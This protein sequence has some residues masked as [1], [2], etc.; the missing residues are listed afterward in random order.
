V[1]SRRTFIKTLVTAAVF[2]PF[3]RAFAL[4]RPDRSLDMYNIHTGESLDITYA[5]DG[6]YD[7]DALDKI[8]YLLRCHY[9]NKVKPID[10]G[11]LDLLCEIKDTLGTDEQIRIISGYRS[12]EYN[13]YLRSIGRHVAKHSYHMRG[14]AIDFTLPG[15]RNSKLSHVAKSFYAGGVGT[16][17]EFVHIDT[18]PVRYW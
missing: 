9:T 6:R 12:P 1:I 17:N 13:E 18:G 11:V 15:F 16:Y 14:V 4:R 3:N 2:Y 7:V 10:V 5:V 8:N